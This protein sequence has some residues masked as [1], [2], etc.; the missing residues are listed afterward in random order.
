[1]PVKVV[2]CWCLWKASCSLGC[3]TTE[4][5]RKKQL[6]MSDNEAGLE[7]LKKIIAAISFH[8]VRTYCV[9][10]SGMRALQTLLL[11][12]TVMLEGA[13]NSI[14]WLVITEPQ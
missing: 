1:M 5:H 13:T 10:D 14:D 8:L 2:G 12:P 9:L 4:I 7:E 3:G 6:K 11:I